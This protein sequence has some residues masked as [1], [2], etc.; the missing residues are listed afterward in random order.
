MKKDVVYVS[1]VI[2]KLLRILRIKNR[3]VVMLQ[4]LNRM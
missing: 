1:T 3:L 2:T 4:P